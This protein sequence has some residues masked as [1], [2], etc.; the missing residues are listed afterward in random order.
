MW[1]FP[2][3]VADIYEATTLEDTAEALRNFPRYA[4]D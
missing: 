4:L 1:R 2:R 3:S